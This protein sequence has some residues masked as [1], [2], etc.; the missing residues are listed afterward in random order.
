MS[1]S[2]LLPLQGCSRYDQC[3]CRYLKWDDRRQED[4]RGIDN[5]VSNQYYE[6][7]DKRGRRRGRRRTD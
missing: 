2:P 1:N 7:D 5:W 4:R 6:G 3:E